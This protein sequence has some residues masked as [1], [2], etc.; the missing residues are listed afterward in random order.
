[1]KR[2]YLFHVVALGLASS[3]AL[4][5][6]GDGKSAD[7]T[8][9]SPTTVVGPVRPSTAVSVAPSTRD[10]KADDKAPLTTGQALTLSQ[11]L[12]KD[13]QAKGAKV[14]MSVPFGP[15]ATFVLTGV[16]DWST[17]MGQFTLSTTRSDGVPVPDSQVFWNAGAVLTELDGL[18]AAMAAK[19]RTGVRYVSRALDA[20]GVSLDQLITFVGS[21]ATD[22]AENPILLRQADTAFVGTQMIDGVSVDGYRYGKSKYWV[23]PTAGVLRR[24]DAAF[25]R[26]DAPVVVTLSDHG[27][28]AVTMPNPAEVVDGAT[29]PDVLAALKPSPTPA[30]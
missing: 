29:I 6:C 1:M 25:A 4:T 27:P 17:H 22:R 16:V 2:A 20:K 15:G 12:V 30:S 14:T 26:Y 23:D 11:M 21:L 8:S 5:A 3:L 28:H 19:G 7:S 13:M 9:A 10:P 18:T 24:V